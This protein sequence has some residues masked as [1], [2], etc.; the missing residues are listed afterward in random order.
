MDFASF[1]KE[2]SSIPLLSRED[3]VI[4]AR[5]AAAT[6]VR[7]DEHTMVLQLPVVLW[8]SAFEHL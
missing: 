3:E 5:K 8:A 7:I 6:C 4:C 1:S 2:L